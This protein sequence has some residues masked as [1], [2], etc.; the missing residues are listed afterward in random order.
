MIIQKSY[1]AN[2]TRALL[3]APMALALIITGC[4]GGDSS[5]PA[6]P[7]ASP[8]L[9]INLA[10][11][12]AVTLSSGAKLEL[13]P[14]A[15]QGEIIFTGETKGAAGAVEADGIVISSEYEIN[16]QGFAPG[17]VVAPFIVTLP[18]DTRLLPQTSILD[19]NGFVAQTRNESTG[20]WQSVK[21]FVDYDAATGKV[22]FQTGHLSSWRVKYIGPDVSTGTQ[23]YTYYTDNFA[24]HYSLPMALGQTSRHFPIE[25]MV[26]NAKGSG[27]WTDPAAP[28]YVEDLGRALEQALTYYLGLSGSSGK[29][30]SSPAILNHVNVYVTYLDQDSG[31]TS[32]P[33]GYIRIKAQLENWGEL[34][35]TAAHELMHLLQDQYYTKIGAWMN[36]WFFEASANLMSARATGMSRDEQLVY[37]TKEMAN[38]LAV[39]LDAS[40]QGSNYAEADFLNWLETRIGKPIV[41]DVMQEDATWDLTALNK[42]LNTGTSTLGS[43]FSEYVLG[44]TVGAYDLKPAHLWHNKMLTSVEP[45]WRYEFEQGHLSANAVEIRSN[46]EID[47]MLVASSGRQYSQPRLQSYSYLGNIPHADLANPLEK[48]TASGQPV[49]VK[50]FGKAGTPGVTSSVFHQV[51]INPQVSDDTVW[52][53]YIFDYYLLLPPRVEQL[54]NGKVT[55]S[56]DGGRL[57]SSTNNP[58]IAGFNVYVGE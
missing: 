46:A 33:L 1:V 36:L 40:S 48:T 52:N 18:I 47:A 55:W 57:P 12:G 14:G 25:D 56:Y 29:L 54:A 30:F 31:D 5:P 20:Q 11:G 15:G 6:S 53:S 37:Y 26:W 24:I 4:G 9:S 34:R 35:T 2:Q 41:A 21:G 32:L 17:H 38:Y 7:P 3:L 51:I 8:P 28:N 10:A 16:A 49:V 58:A 43:L 27:I 23:Q 13:M 44:A 39:P 42:V 50:H 45:G 19:R 22:R